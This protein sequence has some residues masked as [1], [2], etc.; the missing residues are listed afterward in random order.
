MNYETHY[1]ACL[2][3][4]NV[5]PLPRKTNRLREK[6]HRKKLFCYRCGCMVNHLE[7]RTPEDLARFT[8]RLEAG[9][10]V[11]EAKDSLAFLEKENSKL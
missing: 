5:I 11:S 2:N 8:Q 10:F 4:G 1:F 9:E 7:C 3:C 6:N